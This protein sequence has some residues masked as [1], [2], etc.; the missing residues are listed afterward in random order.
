MNILLILEAL[1]TK[2]KTM[3]PADENGIQKNADVPKG[4]TEKSVAVLV[5]ELITRATEWNKITST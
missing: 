3:V 2:Y 1:V 5:G 4:I